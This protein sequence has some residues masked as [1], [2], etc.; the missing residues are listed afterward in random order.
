MCERVL[1]I[2]FKERRA[3]EEMVEGDNI[4]LGR[5]C[6]KCTRGRDHAAVI[7]LGVEHREAA[8]LS[9]LFREIQLKGVKPDFNICRVAGIQSRRC[10]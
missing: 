8:V 7:G 9:V 3:T 1:T 6:I 2:V 10:W 5:A 4:L